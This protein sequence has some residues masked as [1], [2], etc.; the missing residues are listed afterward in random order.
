MRLLVEVGTGGAKGGGID[1][2]GF[3]CFCLPG[4][5]I[6]GKVPVAFCFTINSTG[7]DDGVGVLFKSYA[8]AVADILREAAQAWTRSARAPQ[9]TPVALCLHC[10]QPGEI[11][12]AGMQ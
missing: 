2:A 5:M 11:R 4:Q 12:A 10:Q 3:R 6:V 9:S 1:W 8:G 7:P